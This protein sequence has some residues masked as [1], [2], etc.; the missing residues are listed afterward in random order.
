[1]KFQLVW[2]EHLY[3]LADVCK[4]GIIIT[5]GVMWL[6]CCQM[7][8]D[9][10]NNDSIVAV[11]MDGLGHWDTNGNQPVQCQPS[12]IKTKIVKILPTADMAFFNTMYK[13]KLRTTSLVPGA[14]RLLVDTSMWDVGE[15]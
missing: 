10:C 4:D 8:S 3:V 12:C 1:M 5:K 2:V 11:D 13:M 6:Q 14:G 7:S 9:S 15:V